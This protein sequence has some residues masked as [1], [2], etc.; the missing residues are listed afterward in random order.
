MHGPA[1]EPR[2]GDPRYPSR[3]SPIPHRQGATD[4][5][6]GYYIRSDAVALALLIPVVGTAGDLVE[7]MF[8]RAVGIKD[9]N[10]MV[11]GLDIEQIF[12]S[13]RL[14]VTESDSMLDFI[15]ILDRTLNACKGSHM[16]TDYV[17]SEYYA[18]NEFL[19]F[20]AAD[21]LNEET[22][23]LIKAAILFNFA[24]FASFVLQF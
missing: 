15:K 6:E 3:N 16:N 20:Y 7:S 19:R 23:H 14:S 4:F 18:A 2:S 11:Y 1:D 21:Y 5:K 12:A 22:D 9:S 8:K 10:K 13:Y 17:G 24:K